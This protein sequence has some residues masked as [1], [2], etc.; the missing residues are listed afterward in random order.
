MAGE[1]PD[2]VSAETQR[3]ELLTYRKQNAE[4]TAKVHPELFRWT[5]LVAQ[6]PGNA[7]LP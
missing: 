2:G 5:G 1:L 6:A 4:V 7:E 3:K